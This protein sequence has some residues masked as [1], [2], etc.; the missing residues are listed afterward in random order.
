MIG[1]C[2]DVQEEEDVLSQ[3]AIFEDLVRSETKHWELW[4]NEEQLGPVCD[5]INEKY[6]FNLSI[7][8]LL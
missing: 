4:E 1:C 3:E 2:V 5:H 6:H 8:V 7:N